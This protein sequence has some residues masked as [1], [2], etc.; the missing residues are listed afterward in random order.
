MQISGPIKIAIAFLWLGL[1][2][3]TSNAGTMVTPE[4]QSVDDLAKVIRMHETLNNG[5]SPQNWDDLSKLYDLERINKSIAP[6]GT[7]PIQDRYQFLSQ[8]LPYIDEK[9]SR[10]LLI[11]TVPLSEKK[12]SEDQVP[13]EWRYLIYQ[14]PDGTVIPTRLSEIRVQEMLKNANVTITPKAHLPRVE[15]E[16]YVPGMEPKST[17]NPNDVEFL[18]QHPEL[19]PTRKGQTNEST[20]LPT[21][22][23][24]T[25]AP[26]TT[27]QAPAVESGSNWFLILGG[28]AVALVIGAVAFRVWKK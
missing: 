2:A 7:A 14:R 27:A 6:R 21:T 25:S 17:A 5:A 18:K 1:C 13:R 8:E 24:Q 11:R 22:R 12:T 16:D 3:Q 9:D 26:V 23:P 4:R 28:V 19:D 20:P 15:Y 10:V